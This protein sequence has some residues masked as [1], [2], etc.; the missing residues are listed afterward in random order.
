[1]ETPRAR[2]GRP[3]QPASWRETRRD[4]T[5][6][7][8]ELNSNSQATFRAFL[9]RAIFIRRMR[10]P[11]KSPVQTLSLPSARAGFD[12]SMEHPFFSLANVPPFGVCR[13]SQVPGHRADS[14]EFLAVAQPGMR[15]ALL[16]ASPV[17]S[18]SVELRPAAAPRCGSAGFSTAQRMENVIDGLHES[19]APSLRRD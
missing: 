13:H 8:R 7:W 14:V 15:S 5:G 12:F 4:Q 6:C 17:Q 9:P 2:T 11:A 18:A 1:M 10:M 16:P 19:D 3:Q